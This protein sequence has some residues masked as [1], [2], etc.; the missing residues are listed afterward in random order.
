[1]KGENWGREPEA[2][3]HSTALRKCSTCMVVVVAKLGAAN[4]LTPSR[5]LSMASRT[6]DALL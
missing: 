5:T 2:S 4:G 1:M 6:L 3:V